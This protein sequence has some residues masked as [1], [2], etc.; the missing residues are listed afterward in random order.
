[1]P[2]RAFLAEINFEVFASM[3]KIGSY[4]CRSSSFFAIKT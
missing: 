2:L 4:D 3:L 1:M